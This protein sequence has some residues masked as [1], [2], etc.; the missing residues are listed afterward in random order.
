MIC[1]CLLL[2]AADHFTSSLTGVRRQ[3][4]AAVVPLIIIA[5]TPAR[6]SSLLG[7]TFGERDDMVARIQTLE[8]E[9]LR[10]GNELQRLATLE[11]ENG[12][13]RRLLS[14]RDR[15]ALDV[16]AVEIIGIVPDAGTQQVV[17][18][19]GASNG[20]VLGQAVVDAKG[21]VGQILSVTPF[22]A[23]VLLLTDASHAVPVQIARTGQRLIVGGLGNGSELE[24]RHVGETVDITMGDLL[25]T[26]GL[27]RTFPAD[28]PV[29]EVIEVG[30]LA[31]DGF[32]RVR[33]RPL[34][35]LSKSTHVLL[36]RPTVGE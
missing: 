15:A 17:I 22:S 19:K 24:V 31:V 6:I 36:V 16:E 33:A 32:L 23:R 3:L 11:A 4:E 25:T 29:A 34:A 27:G 18:D 8:A 14:T 30:A 12:R 1:A 28:L 20:V 5:D 21:L 26:S 10:L 9:N 13:L 7:R 2:A 35:E